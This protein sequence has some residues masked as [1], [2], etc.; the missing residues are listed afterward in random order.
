M[1][2]IVTA[3]GQG[4]KIWP[5][6]R[7][8]KPKQFQ[9]VV[10]SEPLYKQTIN[11]LLKGYSAQDIFV[12]TKRRYYDIAISQAPEVLRE[13]FI[14]EPDVAKDRGPGEGLA[15]ATLADLHPNE[16]FIIVQADCLRTPEEDFLKTL[17]AAEKIERRDRKFMSGGVKA[18]YPVLGVDYLKFGQ[19]VSEEDGVEIYKVDEFI[20]RVED[21]NQTRKLIENFH[22]GTHSNHN[23]WFPEL[24][25]EAYQ[26]YR[27]D[28]FEGINNVYSLMKKGASAS[29]I[30]EAYSELQ[31]GPTELVTNNLFKEGYA[32]LLPY[33]WT[34]IGTWD[35][36]YEFFDTGGAAHTEGNVVISDTETSLI[37]CSNPN[38]IV[39]VLGVENLIIVDTE[40]ALLVIPRDKSSKVNDLVKL[41]GE[42]KEKKY[43]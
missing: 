3:G 5:L 18:T 31:A 12:S 28:W 35:S 14:I 9:A 17:A 1:K 25:M 4:K 29:E 8:A 23:C 20:P 13:N 33:K 39:A 38:K 34:D 2:L 40:D 22:V 15:F 11:T 27:P 30:D 26:K 32:I 41:M 7:E 36:V 24:M 37:K 42:R 6:S 19:R 43:L 16:P 21:Y 10:G